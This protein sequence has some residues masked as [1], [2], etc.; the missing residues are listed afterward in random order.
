M[1]GVVSVY[2]TWTVL[3]SIFECWPVA[4]FWDPTIKGGHCMNQYVVWFTNA[5]MNILTDFIIV[6]LPI[7]SIRSLNLPKR[8]RRLLILVFGLAGL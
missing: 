8:Q 3:G 4:F 6:I 5:G 2:G 7:R 1:L